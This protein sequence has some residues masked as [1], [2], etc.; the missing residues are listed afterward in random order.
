MADYIPFVNTKVDCSILQQYYLDAKLVRVSLES[1]DNIRSSLPQGMHLWVDSAIDMYHQILIQK[2]WPLRILEL[3]PNEIRANWP[4]NVEGTREQDRAFQIWQNWQKIF[5]K[6]KNYNILADEKAW[7]KESLDKI[8][9]FVEDVLATCLSYKPTWLSVPQLPLVDK[10]ERNK[11]NRMLALA[12]AEWKKNSGFKG[13]LI[14][15]LIFTGHIQLN[16]KQLR[17]DKLKNAIECYNTAGAEAIWIVDTTLQEAY[18]NEN[19]RMRYA[20]LIDFHAK[21]KQHLPQSCISIS[22]PYWGINLVLWARQLCDYAGISLGSRYIYHISG[23]VPSQASSRIALAP[24]RRW[25]VADRALRQWLDATLERLNPTDE[26]YKSVRELRDNFSVLSTRN[27]SIQQ[28]ATF[29]KKWFDK[30][31]SVPPQGRALALYQDLSTAFVIGSQLPKLPKEAVPYCSVAIRSP[32]KVAEQLM[33]NC[34]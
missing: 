4:T 3:T 33:L 13:K 28:S 19:Y 15:P 1:I 30:I 22:G 7:V 9:E 16:R 29:Y 14:L 26:T 20:K 12:T 6:R 32:G 21:V 17:D 2:N 34:L 11:I 18:P 24:L 25:V 5:G 31:E 10:G 8:Q 23:G 27:A